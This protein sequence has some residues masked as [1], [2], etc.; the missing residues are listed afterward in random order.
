MD[1]PCHFHNLQPETKEVSS[2]EE[3]E[4]EEEEKS[5][6]EEVPPRK[7][8]KKT[9]AKILVPDSPPIVSPHPVE[10]VYT[11]NARRQNKEKEKEKEKETEKVKATGK[12]KGKGKETAKEKEKREKEKEKEKEKERKEKEK[13][14]EKEITPKRGPG[15]PR[16]SDVT[17]E[18]SET[19]S[20]FTKSAAKEKGKYLT[21]FGYEWLHNTCWS[22]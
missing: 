6:A 4:E 20:K 5:E 14:K 1:N 9:P 19:K 8:Q 10:K 12:G 11:K 13:K 17:P 2:E 3:E 22:W 21:T 15:R 7:S 16:K 18:R